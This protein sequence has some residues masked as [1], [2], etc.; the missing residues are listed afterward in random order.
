MIFIHIHSFIYIYVME[1]YVSLAGYR[2]IEELSTTQ[3]SET[4]KDLLKQMEQRPWFKPE[5][6]VTL[7]TLNRNVALYNECPSPPIITWQAIQ[8]QS[9]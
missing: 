8:T 1:G 9:K 6:S 5:E 7:C 3:H 4:T 2:C